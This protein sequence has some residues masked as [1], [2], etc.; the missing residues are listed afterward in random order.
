MTEARTRIE[1]RREQI[2]VLLREGRSI[3]EV[4][5]QL[6]VTASCVSIIR[7]QY[8]P[9]LRT[10]PRQPDISPAAVKSRRE[11]IGV[12]L[13][14]TNFSLSE[15]ANKIGISNEAVRLVQEKYFPEFP[16]RKGGGATPHWNGG[17]ATGESRN[18][19]ESR[20][21]L[22]AQDLQAGLAQADVA[23]KYRVSRTTVSRWNR[24]MNTKGV[25]ALRK[26]LAPG[27]P[28]KLTADQLATAVEIYQA[29]P[30]SAGLDSPRW[31]TARFADAIFTRLGVRYDPDH[32]SRI[33]HRLGL[34]ER[35][36]PERSAARRARPRR[37]ARSR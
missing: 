29:G 31:T 13:R 10:R 2:G 18:E 11:V 32:V 20:R 5:R 9:G 12:F 34:R 4:A 6:G 27:R 23:R 35:R 19:M 37:R 26:R 7:K 16:R 28:S 1:Q 21:L 30:I 8:F 25:E 14:E 15:I 33:M 22:A 17:G 24:E 3:A 36:S